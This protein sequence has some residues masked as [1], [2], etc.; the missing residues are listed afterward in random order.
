VRVIILA[1]IL[2]ILYGCTVTSAP[3][4]TG[5]NLNPTMSP[6]VIALYGEGDAAFATGDFQ[7]AKEKHEAALKEAESLEDEPG[8][9]FNLFALGVD[10]GSLKVYLQACES[11]SKALPYFTKTQN[12]RMQASTLG[13]LGE[14]YFQMGNDASAIEA[15]DQALAITPKLL[16]KASDADKQVIFLVQ[17]N[18][19]NSKAQAHNKLGQSTQAVQSYRDA[20]SY[21]EKVGKKAEAASAL[22]FAGDILPRNSKRQMRQ[23]KNLA[24]QWLCSKKWATAQ[25]PRWHAWVLQS[26]TLMQEGSTTLKASFRIF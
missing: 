23:L 3:P 8:V 22:W 14:V 9:A 17:A 12:L 6:P 26:H 1:C 4:E 13:S 25:V 21:F 2:L 24:V 10:Y 19:L 16:E 15:F 11:L 20:A 7:N 18:A 5:L